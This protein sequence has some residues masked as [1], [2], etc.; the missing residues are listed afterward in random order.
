MKASRRGRGKSETRYSSFPVKDKEAAIDLRK[1]GELKRT[2]K[3][4]EH[5]MMSQ[6]KSAGL[7]ENEAS[8][9]KRE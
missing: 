8:S 3:P 5:R 1:G 6:R 2:S 4:S 9:S 7:E